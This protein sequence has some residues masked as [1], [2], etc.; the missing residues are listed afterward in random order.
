MVL[1]VEVGCGAHKREGYLRCDI[2]ESVGPDLVFNAEKDKWPLEDNS[3]D[4]VLSNNLCEHLRDLDHYMR[5][6]WRVLKA[7]GKLSILTPY[8]K[9]KGAVADPDHVRFF[10]EDSMMFYSKMCLGSD[11]RPVDRGAVD[12]DTTLIT[13]NFDQKLLEKVGVSVEDAFKGLDKNLYWDCVDFLRYDLKKVYPLRIG[14]VANDA[15]GK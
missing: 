14:G 4:E 10:C 15:T 9:H 1:K 5:E 7:D 12:F 3:V 2:A 6:A 13:F 11:G 8:F